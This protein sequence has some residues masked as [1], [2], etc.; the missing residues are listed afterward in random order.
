MEKQFIISVFDELSNE[1]S[2]IKVYDETSV[3]KA[4]KLATEKGYESMVTKPPMTERARL[5]SII[6]W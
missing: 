6:R 2:K 1:I 5:E 3:L 4:V